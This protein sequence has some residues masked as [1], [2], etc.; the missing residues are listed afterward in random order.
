MRDFFPWLIVRQKWHTAH[1]YLEIRDIVLIQDASAV[2]GH[3]KIGK[4]FNVL[5]STDGKVGNVEVA[6]KHT[7]PKEKPSIYEGVK[8]ATGIRPIQRLVLLL[9]K[10]EAT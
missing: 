7:K 3:Q 4:T 2:Q 10:E 9:A 1:C 6:N 5:P 8:Y